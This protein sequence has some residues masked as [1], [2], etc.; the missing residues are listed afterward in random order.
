MGMPDAS[1]ACLQAC[2]ADFGLAHSDVNPNP[3]TAAPAAPAAAA[4][5]AAAG[6]CHAMLP[7]SVTSRHE[8]M[9][10]AEQT[11]SGYRTHWTKPEEA[12]Q[13][14]VQKGMQVVKLVEKGRGV[15]V[16]FRKGGSL[17]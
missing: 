3:T 7:P 9:A 6:C 5:A 15:L 10:A 8:Q 13:L 2:L 11:P 12:R 1:P 16:A 17:G 14:I 4:A